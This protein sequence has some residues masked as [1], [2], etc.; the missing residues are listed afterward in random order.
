MRQA[1]SA[2]A[3]NRACCSRMETFLPLSKSRR[4]QSCVQAERSRLS[5]CREAPSE[6]DCLAEKDSSK[7]GPP[8]AICPFQN[9][10]PFPKTGISQASPICHANSVQQLIHG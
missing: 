9:Q 4:P 5:L 8:T 1:A 7:T 6:E 3:H 2:P 10:C